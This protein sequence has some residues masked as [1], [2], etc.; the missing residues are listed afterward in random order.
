MR[1]SSDQL[2]KELELRTKQMTALNEMGALLQCSGTVQEACVVVANCV[3]KLFPEAPSGALYLFRSSRDLIEA[4]VRWG[5]KDMLAPTFPPD[6]C[7]SLRRG[8]P[9]WSESSGG[10]IA[11]QH[12]TKNSNADCLCVPMVA[13]GNTIGILHLEFENAADSETV[14]EREA[15]SGLPSATGSQRGFADCPF[16]GQPATA[17]DSS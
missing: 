1:E 11:C 16:A 9:H 7:W 14:L 2:V 4:A 6:A 13:Q 5:I 3:Q 8:Q 17:R 10:G 15:Y 12:L